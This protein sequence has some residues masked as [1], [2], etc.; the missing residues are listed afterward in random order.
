MNDLIME[1]KHIIITNYLVYENQGHCVLVVGSG[2]TVIH[3]TP[4]YSQYFV[5]R[6]E[7]IDPNIG[8][9]SSIGKSIFDWEGSGRFIFAIRF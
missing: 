2:G 4:N 9:V 6:F 5:D 8:Y 7:Y 3:H 1:G